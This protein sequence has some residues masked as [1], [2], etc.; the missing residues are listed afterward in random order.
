MYRSPTS[1]NLSTSSR[2]DQWNRSPLSSKQSTPQVSPRSNSAEEPMMNK[3]KYSIS[4]AGRPPIVNRN[5]R[6]S[7]RLEKQLSFDQ[8]GPL[9][10]IAEPES[11]GGGRSGSPRGPRLFSEVF[12]L[13][14]SI[15][16]RWASVSSLHPQAQLITTLAAFRF[17]RLLITNLYSVSISSKFNVLKEL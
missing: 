1:T 2:M 15:A 12:T 4:D 3:Q 14:C 17:S 7:S 8:R 5:G 6:R 13:G 9:S 11:D 16:Y 10:P